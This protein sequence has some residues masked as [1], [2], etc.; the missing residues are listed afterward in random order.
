[1]TVD[2]VVSEFQRPHQE[3]KRRLLLWL[4]GCWDQLEA[5]ARRGDQPSADW[6]A[7]GIPLQPQ[8]PADRAANASS[9]AARSRRLRRLDE[10][11]LIERVR[12][13]NRTSAL[14]LTPFGREVARLVNR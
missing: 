12:Q 13:N 10:Q 7:W 11:G 5:Q 3:K 2:R 14:K 8:H 9:R 6:L 4:A 1:M